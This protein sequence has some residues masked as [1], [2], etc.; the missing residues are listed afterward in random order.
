MEGVATAHR[1]EV[2]AAAWALVVCPSVFL[3]S[4]VPTAH[5]AARATLGAFIFWFVVSAFARRNTLVIPALYVAY[6]LWCLLAFAVSLLAIDPGLALR[7]F[8]T[9]LSLG[10]LALGVTN[11]I[12]WS[13]SI[14]V[15]SWA[16]LISAILAYISNYIP[17]EHFFAEQYETEILGRYVGTLGN[18]NAFGRAMVQAFFAGTALL[19]FYSRGWSA[20][21]CI[22]LLGAMGLA[23]IESSSRTAMLGLAIGVVAFYGCLRLRDLVS[24]LNVMGLT[25]VIGGIVGVFTYF[26]HHFQTAIDRMTIFFSFLGITPRVRSGERSID[27]RID[28]ANRALEVSFDYPLGVGLDNFRTFVGTYAHSNY[29]EI[30][31]STGLIGLVVY[32]SMFLALL[33]E[34]YRKLVRIG[35]TR[36]LVFLILAV[37]AIAVM[38]LF[39]VSYY[40]KTMWLYLGLLSGMLRLTPTC[41]T[42]N[43]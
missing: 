38:D 19:L 2:L 37:L 6:F 8:L 42:T 5:L 13:G 26:P 29:L 11:A 36:I 39:N 15:W 41:S 18:A 9:V 31:V 4:N 27:D 23:T 16:F 1:R 35:Q 33:G 40:S 20:T 32:Y 7:K 22:L 17:V 30:L 24:P 10:A 43:K 21:L 12:V 14:R 3:L 34:A 25:G 28:L